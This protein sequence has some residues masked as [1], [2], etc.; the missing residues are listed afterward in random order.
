VSRIVV[1]GAGI[2]GASVACHAARAGAEVTLLDAVRPATGVTADS[3]AWIGGPAGGDTPDASTA[4]RRCVLGD[5]RRLEA[6]LPDVGVRW[7]GSLLWGSEHLAGHDLA[8]GEQVLDA[9]QV[10]RLEPAL[11]S[12]PPRAVHRTTD[13][14]VDP[15]VVTHALVRGACD[16]GCELLVG[17]AASALRVR[18]SRVVGVETASGFVPA[19]VVVVATGADAPML[20]DP[21]GAAMPVERSPALLLRFTAPPGLV[22]T[23]VASGEL[24]VRQTTDGHLLVAGAYGGQASQDDLRGTA[25]RTLDRLT[26]TF[27][28]AAADLRLVSVRV[29]MRP[30]PADGLPIIGPLPAVAGVYLAVMHAGV[31]LAPA[32]GRLVAGELV[33]GA[34]AEELRGLGLDRGTSARSAAGAG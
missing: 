1:V 15:V 29:G 19:D 26:S 14:V 7:T 16:H 21:L 28:V 27:A 13:G 32:V 33:D 6:E 9:R 24:E 20:V 31:T 34:D 4:L 18:G 23:L 8:P 2:V 22:R 17:V 5:W 10:S 30:M 12:A 3:F 11:R 25:E